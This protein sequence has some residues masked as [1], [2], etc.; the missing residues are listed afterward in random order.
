MSAKFSR[1]NS[2]FKKADGKFVVRGEVRWD[3]SNKNVFFVGRNPTSDRQF[4][5]AVN[6]IYLF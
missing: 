6:L 4:T 3:L 2:H 1:L 5:R